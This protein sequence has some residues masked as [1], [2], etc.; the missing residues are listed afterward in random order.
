MNKLVLLFT[1]FFLFLQN[2]IRAQDTETTRLLDKKPKV[3][4]VLSGGGA[5]GLAHIPTLQALDSL[6]IVPDLIVGNSMGSI[7]GGLYAMGYSGN[8]IVE[9]IKLTHWDELMGGGVSLKNVGPEEKAEFKHYSIELD[10]RDGNL[11]L[12]SFLVNDQNLREFIS[13]LTFPV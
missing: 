3:A 11:K 12:G 6:G 8:D 10:W 2:G 7:V 13:R 9:I 5:K 4:L 1:L